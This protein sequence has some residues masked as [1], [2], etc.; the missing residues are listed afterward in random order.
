MATSKCSSELSELSRYSVL[1][2]YTVD[3]PSAD[4][5]NARVTARAERHLITKGTQRW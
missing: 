5:I 4:Q 3:V 1:T 2:R